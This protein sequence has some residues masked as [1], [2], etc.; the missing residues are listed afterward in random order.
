MIK[1]LNLLC[2]MFLKQILLTGQVTKAA[3][4]H[5]LAKYYLLEGR[6]DDAIRLTTEVITGGVHNLNTQ[7]FG[8]DKDVANKDVI[9][10]M[11]RVENKHCR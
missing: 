4:K 10:D 5:L 8:I 1:D 3:C 6:F 2:S 9:W 11:F 7:R